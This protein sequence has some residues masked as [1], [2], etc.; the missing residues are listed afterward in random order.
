MRKWPPAI[1]HLMEDT[2]KVDE[3]WE[4][5]LDLER[6]SE[7]WD[8]AATNMPIIR[9]PTIPLPSQSCREKIYSGNVFSILLQR[10]PSQLAVL[11]IKMKPKSMKLIRSESKKE[12]PSSKTSKATAEI[13][14]KIFFWTAGEQGSYEDKGFNEGPKSCLGCGWKAKK[15]ARMAEPATKP[16]PV[17]PSSGSGSKS[18]NSLSGWGSP[19]K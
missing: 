5:L 7:F 8:N 16:D 1:R 9:A 2:A 4:D 13:V 15:L 10:F 6:L 18:D 12:T 14:V 3:T 17:K 19:G 11:V